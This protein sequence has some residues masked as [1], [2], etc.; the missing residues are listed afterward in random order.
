MVNGKFMCMGTPQHL[1]AK[2]GKGYRIQLTIVSQN[3]LE[4]IRTLMVDKF[5]DLEILPMP[6]ENKLVF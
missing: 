4:R 3:E 5:A 6:A 1:K 2:Y